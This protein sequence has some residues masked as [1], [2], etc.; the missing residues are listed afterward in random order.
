MLHISLKRAVSFALAAMMAGGVFMLAGCSGGASNNGTTSASVPASG[1]A[2]QVQ[3]QSTTLP[4]FTPLSEDYQGYTF[5]ILGIEANS[6]TW[7]IATYSEVNVEGQNGDPI[8]DAIYKRNSEVQDLY[9]IKLGFVPLQFG[10]NDHANVAKRSIMAGSNDFDIALMDGMSIPAIMLNATG[11]MEDL[12]TVPN[13]DL[14]KSWWDQNSVS[15]LSIAHS[16]YMVTGDINLH[17]LASSITMFADKALIQ[18]YNLENPY[19]L[20]R[21]GTWTWDKVGEMS[22]AVTKDL[23]G[24]GKMTMNDQWGI[25]AEYLA[26][27]YNVRQSGERVTQKDSSDIPYLTMNT[28]RAV[29]AAQKSLDVTFNQSIALLASEI[30]GAAVFFDYALPKFQSNQLLFFYNQLLVGL[31]L[32]SMDADFE[33]LPPPK[34][35]DSQDR[36]YSCLNDW[37]ATYVWIPTTNTDLAR[38][39]AV[40]QAMGYYSQQEITPAFMDV[41]VTNKVLRDQDSKDMLDIIMQSRTYDLGVMYNWAN[42]LD[43]Y[44]NMAYKRINNLASQYAA[45]E[46]KITTAMQKSI[47]S[48]L[49]K[50]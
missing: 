1:A 35:D 19:D 5:N 27:Q 45:Q 39:G 34:L 2:T 8:N 48:I 25:F 7:T 9:N 40:T 36:Y 16:L 43:I 26:M 17:T 4:E 32:R 22:K 18:Q 29:A 24:D 46:S 23:D 38:T 20:V 15:E 12:N 47:N 30:P 37:W 44:N 50:S 6:S 33:V 31:N 21:A 3:T 10:T 28:D 49:N 13:L 42:L 14:T 11:N 41:T